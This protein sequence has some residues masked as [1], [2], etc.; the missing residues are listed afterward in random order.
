M[1][2]TSDLCLDLE[3]LKGE[4]ELD[5]EN[6]EEE[7]AKLHNELRS[8]EASLKRMRSENSQLTQTIAEKNADVATQQVLI[9]STQAD[10]DKIG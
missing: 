8:V 2:Q 5:S 3:T 6:I 7:Y 9:R 10:I 4:M 1:A